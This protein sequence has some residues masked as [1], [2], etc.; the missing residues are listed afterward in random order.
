MINNILRP[1]Q[2]SGSNVMRFE[3][4]FN[5]QGKGLDGTIKRAAHIM[6]LDSFAFIRHFI[7]INRHLFE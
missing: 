5:V 3:V 4:H 7:A 1:L 2:E 6:L